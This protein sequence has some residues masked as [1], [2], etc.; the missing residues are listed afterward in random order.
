P[1]PCIF[2]DLCLGDIGARILEF[3]PAAMGANLGARGYE[4]FHIGVGADDGADVAPVEHGASL[5]ARRPG[6][7]IALELE[8]GRAHRRHDGDEGGRLA[9]LARA[10]GALVDP[11]HVERSRRG[12]GRPLVG[13]VASGRDHRHADR[14]VEGA[15]VE[16]GEPVMLSQPARKRSLAGCGRAVDGDD[17][18]HW[19]CPAS[20][21][22]SPR[23][24]P[25]KSGKL[26]AIIE[27]SSIVTGLCA[28]S[29]ST[30]K[31]IAMRWSIWVATVPS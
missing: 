15:R 31:D 5:P 24:S 13:R 19:P 17:E 6:G 4:D 20:V 14:A 11:R 2:K 7:E 18:A 8:D 27:A 9:R 26:V 29:P 25:A 21:A 30:T 16:K 28:P 23:M 3:E 12:K 10:D 22:P 1:F